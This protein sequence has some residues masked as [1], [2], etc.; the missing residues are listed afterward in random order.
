MAI[1]GLR[2]TVLLRAA[3]IATRTAMTIAGVTKQ[4]RIKKEPFL[5]AAR[6]AGLRPPQ[7]PS[8]TGLRA[9]LRGLLC[10][11]SPAGLSLADN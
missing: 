3:G 4:E 9:R 6:P 8:S 10:A 7:S 5:A 11:S 1:M 2:D